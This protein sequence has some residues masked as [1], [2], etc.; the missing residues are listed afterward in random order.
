MIRLGFHVWHIILKCN[1]LLYSKY[2]FDLSL[3]QCGSSL[4]T[5]IL[6]IIYPYF[7]HV[8]V[9]VYSILLLVSQLQGGAVVPSP[10]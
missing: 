8:T 10:P 3:S 4:F 9:S 1:L 6:S 5:G 2:K 7:L